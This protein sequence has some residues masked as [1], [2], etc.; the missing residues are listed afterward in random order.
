[1]AELAGPQFHDFLQ[2]RMDHGQERQLHEED[3]GQ[4]S[5]PVNRHMTGPHVLQQPWPHDHD[6]DGDGQTGRPQQAPPMQQSVE[7]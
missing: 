4:R 7:P 6:G 3:G 1:M 2:N 5:R